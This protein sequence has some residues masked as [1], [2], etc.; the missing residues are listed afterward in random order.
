MNS[1]DFSLTM[2]LL[3][4]ALHGINPGMGWLFAVS[5]GLQEQRRSAVLGALGPLAL[6]HAIAIAVALVLAAAL[7]LVI[8]ISVM[9]WIAAGALFGFGCY[10]LVRHRHPRYGGMRVGPKDLAIWSFLMASAH[11]AGLMAVPFVLDV[12]TGTG[13]AAHGSAAAASGHAAH[14]SVAGPP[15]SDLFGVVA[16]LTHT[17]GYLA[18]AGMMAVLV[19]QRFGLRGLRTAWI[20]LDLIW[21]GALILTAVLTPLL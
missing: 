7:G 3:L 20:N 6:G 8:P 9:K 5:L 17:T 11:G 18:V 19:F 16:V 12:A 4:G 15:G 13:H 14:L 21:A 1:V 2:L 10:R